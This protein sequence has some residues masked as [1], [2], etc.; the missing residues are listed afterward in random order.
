MKIIDKTK[1]D[2][3]TFDK[4]NRGEVFKTLESDHIYMK[5]TC[6][7]DCDN[8]VCLIDGDLCD[9]GDN[10]KVI[11]LQCELIITG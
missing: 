9:C 6:S 11:P 4:L 2:V 1:K 3:I 5:T 10:L 7:C 8:A